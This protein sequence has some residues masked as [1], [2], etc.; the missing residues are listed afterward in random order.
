MLQFC[1]S[2]LILG[3]DF[4]QV[5]DQLLGLPG[6]GERGYLENQSMLLFIVQGRSWEDCYFSMSPIKRQ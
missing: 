3:F 1:P 2:M 4:E 5:R 6:E